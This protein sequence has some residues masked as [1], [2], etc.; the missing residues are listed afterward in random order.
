MPFVSIK[1]NSHP[2]LVLNDNSDPLPWNYGSLYSERLSSDYVRVTRRGIQFAKV[3]RKDSL[4]GVSEWGH[5][6][7]CVPAVSALCEEI[8]GVES[9]MLYFPTDRVQIPDNFSA[10]VPSAYI[11]S[12]GGEVSCSTRYTGR[13]INVADTRYEISLCDLIDKNLDIVLHRKLDR[14]Y[15]RFDQTP[16]SVYIIISIMSIYIVSSISRNIIS[17]VRSDQIE[18]LNLQHGLVAL[19]FC[20]ALVEFVAL[21]FSSSIISHLDLALAVGLMTYI[22]IGIV[23]YVG[24][25]GSREHNAC[26]SLL[27]TCLLLMTMRVHYTLDNPYIVPLTALFGIRD[28]YKFM[29]IM[30]FDYREPTRIAQGIEAGSFVMVKDIALLAVDCVMF[31]MLL[32]YGVS[33]SGATHS[34]CIFN[35]FI[36]VLVSVLMGSLLFAYNAVH[37]NPLKILVQP[38]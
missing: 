1:D 18:S 34:D 36:I 22:A 35:Q 12:L 3:H 17:V 38:T 27:T 16:L 14:I 24:G 19:I 6:S 30:C 29:S 11:Q 32:G 2:F 5:E 33:R 10:V 25:L 26:I 37:A 21:D 23:A 7:P 9:M 13:Q 8:R 28:W 15:W 31:C 20:L 4:R